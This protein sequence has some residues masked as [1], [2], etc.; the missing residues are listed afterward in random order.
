MRLFHKHLHSICTS[1]I[2]TPAIC[3]PAI[4]DYVINY[5]INYAMHYSTNYTRC[6]CKNSSTRLR[7]SSVQNSGPP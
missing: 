3:N 7:I 1:A 5:A 2:C 6:F 4:C